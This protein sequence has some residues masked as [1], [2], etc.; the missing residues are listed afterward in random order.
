MWIRREQAHRVR[1]RRQAPP[2]AS[3]RLGATTGCT[4]ACAGSSRS[5]SCWWSPSWF[6]SSS[7]PS[8]RTVAPLDGWGVDALELTMGALCIARYFERSW[9]SSS[10]VARLF[11]LVIGVAC[12]AWAFGDVAITVESLGGATSFGA[13]GGRRVLRGLL[14][15][16][17]PGLRVAHPPRQP[18]LARRHLARRAH[19]RPRGRRRVRRLRRCRGAQGHG[20][21]RAGGRDEPGLPARGRPAARARRRRLRR[22]PPGVPAVLRPR[23]CRPRR[24]RHRRRFQPPAARRAASATSPTVR[25]GRSR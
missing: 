11:P 5:P 14:P 8:A 6:P 25:P 23:R 4:G 20:R 21:R 19:R 9:R 15:S 3:R 24:E 10:P 17:L 18:E 7:G 2:A 22:A 1:R 12:I 13:I 16:V